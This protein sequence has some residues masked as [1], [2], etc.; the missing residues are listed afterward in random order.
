MYS[1]I[2]DITLR[3]TPP[4]NNLNFLSHSVGFGVHYPTPVGPIRLDFG[5]LLN[6]PQFE[7]CTN[8]MAACPS[9]TNPAILR[10]QHRFHFFL[11]FG[12][13]F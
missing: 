10:R 1:S 11:T 8:T 5:Y 13:P 2:H 4:P 6:S 12:S 3:T 9:A 7:F